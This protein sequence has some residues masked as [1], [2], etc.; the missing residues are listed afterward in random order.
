MITEFQGTDGA[1]KANFNLRIQE[2]NSDLAG[3]SDLS[4]PISVTLAAAGWAGGDAPY[5]QTITAA[6]LRAEPAPIEILMG[7]GFTKEQLEAAQAANIQ[8]GDQADG[9]IVLY[10]YGDKPDLDLPIKLLVRGDL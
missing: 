8:K 1:T 10:A 7:D 3:K 6:G 5:R 9:S 2:M 4:D